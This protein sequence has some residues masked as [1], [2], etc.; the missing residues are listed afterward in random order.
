MNKT[1]QTARRMRDIQ[2]F[3]VMDLLAQAKTLEA[4]G[5]SIVHMEVGEPDF[6]TIQPIIDAGIRALEQHQTH[7]TAAVGLPELRQA[8]SNYYRKRYQVAVS[9][10]RIIITPGASGALQLLMGVL[11][12]PGD[13]VLMPDPG[14]PCNRHFVRMYEGCPVSIPVDLDQQFQLSTDVLKP[15]WSERSKAL[16]VA[17]PSNPTGTTISLQAMRKLYAELRQHDAW[18]VVDEIYQGLSYEGED[19]TALSISD[20][21]IVVNS[22]SKFFGMTGWRLG[23]LVAPPTLLNDLDKLAQNIFLSAP[24]VSQYAALAAFSSESQQLLEE[25]RKLF[26]ERR[27]VLLQELNAIPNLGFTRPDGAFYIYVDVSAYTD[28]SFALCNRLLNEFGL[29]VTPGIDFG[30]HKASRYIRFAYTTDID[31][32]REGINRFKRCI[33]V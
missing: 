32:I 4:Q 21:V 25:K 8:I 3:H 23:W 1:V 15:L 16:M 29:A 13:E 6:P 17:S 31:S 9:A 11:I 30:E 27:D 12:D 26:N 33:G 19:Y 2:P 10:D 5:R 18:L 22:F 20:D 14:Y 24:T 28:D 7:Y